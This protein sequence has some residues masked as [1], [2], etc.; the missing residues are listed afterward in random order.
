MVKNEMLAGIRL[1]CIRKGRSRR[2][3]EGAALVMEAGIVRSEGGV[4]CGVAYVHVQ[5]QA[6]HVHMG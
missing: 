5:L 4:S 3:E 1:T 6:P 2:Y